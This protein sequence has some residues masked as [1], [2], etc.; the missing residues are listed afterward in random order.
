[1]SPRLRRLLG[2]LVVTVSIAIP[3]LAQTEARSSVESTGATASSSPAKTTPINPKYTTPKSPLDTAYGA[4]IAEYTT[5]KYFLTELVDHL[6]LSDK[7]PSPEKVLG[8]AVGTPNKLTYTKDLYR[9]FRALAAA[10][11]RVRVFVA[12]EKSE[13][14]REQMLVVVSDEANL[15]KLDRYKEITAKLADPRKITDADAQTLISEAKPF[16]WASGSI[17]SPETGS[18]EMLMELAYRLAVEDSPF[19]EDIRKNMIVMITPALEVD[20]RDRMVDLYNYHKAN[21]GKPVPSL[22]Y[23]GKYVAH[24]NNRDGLGMAL[25]LTRN[26]MRTFLEYHPTV[27]HDLHESVPYLYTMTGTG[28]YNAW[29][30]P[31]AIDEFQLLAYHEIEEMTKRGVPGVW[32]HGFYDGWAPNYMLYIATGHNAIGRFY[33]TFGNG[34]ADTRE[35]TLPANQTSRVW[36]RPNPPFPRVNWSMRN[37]INMQQSAI[38]FAMNFVAKE[39]ER[40]L[41]NFYIKSKRA[42]SKAS[43]E[44]PAAYIIPGDTPRPVEAADMVNLLRMQGV[45][46]HRATKEF[47]VKDQKYPAGSYIIRM[48]QPYSRMADMLLDTQYYNVSDPAPYDDTGWTMGAMRNVKTVRVVDKSVLDAPAT[49]LTEDAKVTGQLTGPASAVVYVINHN[50]DNTLA[51]LRFKLKDVKMSA[52]EDS[53]KIGEQQFNTGSFIIKK[54][55]NPQDLRTRLESTVAELGLKAVGIDKLPDVKTHELAVPRIAIVHTW[56]NTQNEGWFRIEFDRLQIPYTYIS[57]QVIRDTPNLRQKFDVLIFPPVGGS[58]QTIVNGLPKRG[59]PIPWKQSD[60]TPNFGNSP[61]QTDDMRGGMSVAGVANLQK[62]IEDGGLFITIGGIAQIPIDYGITNGVSIQQSDKLQARGSIYNSTFADRK[63]PIA[64][65]YDVGLPVYF[66]QTPLFQVAAGGGGG[67]GGGG[68]GGQGGGGASRASGRGGIGDPDVVQAMPQ[69]RPADRSERGDDQEQRES[70]FFVPPQLR[71]R[72]VL[73]FANDEK[74]LLISGMLAGGN[75]LANRPAVVDVPVGR[76]HVVMFATNPMWRHQ[77]QGEFFLVF[78]AALN[79]DNLGVG[80]AEPRGQS[81]RSSMDDQ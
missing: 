19:I 29:L 77:T 27:L 81:P 80:R 53:F 4:K 26:Q 10:S 66:N 47:S 48:D 78:N 33:E 5:E 13:E 70:P 79:Y 2:S 54:D 22:L 14:G 49:L 17:H 44:G 23:W 11:P 15:A 1:M 41:N 59:D 57:D 38:L 56:I 55:G 61:D 18:P 21:P 37:N 16:Y 60:V 34:G 32:T 7:V 67:F 9:Y 30:D 35:R 46:V 6:P 58:A 12:P 28:P 65:G 73:R 69:P 42:I 63:S 51:T 52:A 43:N 36:Y 31:L 75:E 20:G 72:V 39:K 71:P 25:A 8:Y 50:T 24:D 3:V 62:F 64:Y 76:G 45:E 74:N 40:F 68:G